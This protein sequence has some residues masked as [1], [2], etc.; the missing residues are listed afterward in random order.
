MRYEDKKVQTLKQKMMKNK[1]VD[2]NDI[3]EKNKM[4]KIRSSLLSAKQNVGRITNRENL[5]DKIENKREENI[6]NVNTNNVNNNNNNNNN[7]TKI[8]KKGTDFYI[9][10]QGKQFPL[11]QFL[12]LS[13]TNNNIKDFIEKENK[14]KEAENNL[15]KHLLKRYYK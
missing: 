11:K 8:F 4:K 6:N 2:V 7:N 9:D 10:Y 5:Y 12:M 14:E 3:V 15:Y 13:K 1:G